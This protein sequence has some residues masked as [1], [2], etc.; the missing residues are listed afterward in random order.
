MSARRFRTAGVSGLLLTVAA[1]GT[2]T[3][4]PAH[5]VVGQPVN[6]SFAFTA[7]LDID[8][9]RSCSAA[10]VAP[11]WLITAASCFVE[12]PAQGTK[13]PAGKLEKPKPAVI[14]RPDLTRDAGT[15]AN[16][17]ELVPR[18]DRDLVLAKLDKPVTGITPVSLP[19]NPVIEG[20]D[21]WVSG[22]GRTKDE[23]VPDRL[24]YA[25]FTTGSVKATTVGLTAKSD[26]AAICQGDTGGPAFRDVGGRFEL[27]GVNSRSW[28][29]GCVGTDAKE[30]RTNAIDARA[31]DLAGWIRDQVEP[32]VPV[33]D[34]PLDSNIDID[35]DGKA[36]YLVVEDN[37]SVHAWLNRTTD[38]KESWDDQGIIAKGTGAPGN[39]VRFADINGDGRAD[40]LVVDDKGGVYAYVNNQPAGN[41]RWINRGVVATGTGAPGNKVRFADINDDGKADYLVVEDNGSV[42]AWINKTT[43]TKEDW[44]DQGI[45]ATGTGAPGSKIRLADINGDRRADYLV[46]EDNG[47]VHAWINDSKTAKDGWINRGVVATGTGAPGNKVRFADINGD[48]KADY[49]V[50]EDNGSVHAWINRSSGA[51]DDWSDRGI[52]ATGTGAPGSKIRI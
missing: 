37:G 5:A 49:L 42:H 14:G 43:D 48:R 13:I 40:Y 26:G 38:A 19:A 7:K 39:K 32:K 44:A 20:Q 30:T 2:L 8:G 47:S 36:D 15:A 16:V 27:I 46:V 51:K 50:V 3:A 23:W 28:Q 17:T 24:H 29:G 21:V 34:A 31:D 11:Q 6:D 1:A 35:G 10:L 9:E 33:N 12:N 4:A 45:I 41:D 18:E 22:Y 52:I 25:K